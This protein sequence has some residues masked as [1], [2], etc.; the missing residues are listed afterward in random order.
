[1]WPDSLVRD[2]DGRSSAELP[3]LPHTARDCGLGATGFGAWAGRLDFVLLLLLG[4]SVALVVYR[5]RACG[6]SVR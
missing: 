4:V 2:R 1:M 5:C 6:G 3:R